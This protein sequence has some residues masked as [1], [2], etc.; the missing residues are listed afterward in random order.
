[1]GPKEREETPA[2]DTRTLVL[3]GLQGLLDLLGLPDILS[4]LKRAM[5]TTRG[6]IQ[7]PKETKETVESL[8]SLVSQ[9]G[10]LS[11]TSTH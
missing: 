10:V 9:E 3:L 6:I 2:E 4:T 8:V 11:L 1:M 5:M 7:R